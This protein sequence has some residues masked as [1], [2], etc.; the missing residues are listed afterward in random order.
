MAY[1]YAAQNVDPETTSKAVGREIPVKPKFAVNVCKAIKGKSVKQARTFLEDV[2]KLKAAVPF[3]VH[4][5]QVK[6]RAG[7]IGPG[8]YPVNVAKAT[9]RILNDAASNAEYKGLDPDK[10]YVWHACAHRGA[11][12]PGIMPRAQ[13]R[14]TAWDKSTSHIEI[15]LKNES[16]EKAE[17]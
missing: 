17:E 12:I 8:Q 1:G 16:E 3:R 14:A 15:V 6:H 4:K 13:G 9:L 5:R 11:P 2:T 7:G 10:M